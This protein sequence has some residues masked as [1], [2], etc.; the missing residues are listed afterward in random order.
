M[1][2]KNYNE[3][4]PQ[5][6]LML[7]ID[8]EESN[9]TRLRTFAELFADYAPD[10]AA[11]FAEIADEE[12]QHA[13]QL[14][15]AFERRFGELQRTVTEQDVQEVVEA[16]DLDDGEHLVFDDLNLRRALKIV[17]AAERRAEDF[18]RRAVEGATDPELRELY[19]QLAEFEDGHVQWIEARLASLGGSA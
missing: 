1:S 2:A 4:T 9:G 14:E 12:D 8:V 17:L 6:I 5:E 10:S 16:Y 7:A 11:L 13:R 3:L 18:Y 19:R 15:T